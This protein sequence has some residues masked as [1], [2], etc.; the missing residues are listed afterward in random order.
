[1]DRVEGQA[2]P[3]AGQA[4]GAQAVE[5]LSGAAIVTRDGRV[6]LQVA[7]GLAD[8]GSGVMCTPQTRFQISSVSKQFAAIT[9]LLLAESGTLDLAEPVARW[10]PGCPPWWQQVTLHHLLSHTAGVRHWDEG[11]PGFQ[12]S[13]PLDL[14]ERAALIQQ[15]PLVTE[16]GT[17]WQYSSPGF[18]LAGHVIARACGR[19]YAEFVTERLLAPQGLAA[20]TAG[21]V[22]AGPATARGYR[23]G[24]P[25]MPWRLS[26][27]PGTGDICS[28]VGDLARF[29][30]ALHAGS[31][32]G[33]RSVRAMVTRQTPLPEDQTTSDGWACFDGYGYGQFLGHIAGQPVCL[34]PGDN[35][36]FQSVAVWLPAQT[37][38]VVVLSNDEDADI[39]ALLRQL[40]P[41]A[42]G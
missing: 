13:Q 26:T 15:A 30:A 2:E 1:M 35:P 39:E 24:E 28:T 18:V 32:I 38:C 22:P 4:V 16:P 40:I 12:P 41:A 31:L 37:A 23:A 14:A 6:V 34:H 25:V 11:T 27:M 42:L 17:R 29:I 21:D 9:A 33:E 36:G 7:S 10:L 19:P 20:T 8:A 5:G 3:A